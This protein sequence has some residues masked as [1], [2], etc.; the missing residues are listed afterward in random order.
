MGTGNEWVGKACSTG[1]SLGV[2]QVLE[3]KVA[4]AAA[5]TGEQDAK[6]LF[7][8]TGTV[9][10]LSFGVCDADLN[11]ASATICLGTENDTDLFV[12][13]TTETTIDTDEIWE[14]TSPAKFMAYSTIDAKWAIIN[15]ADIGYEVASA[16]ITSGNMTFLCYWWPVTPNGD[17]RVA[18]SDVDL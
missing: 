9:V 7:S 18:G 17:V 1:K 11:G 14:S 16:D 15:N 2:M 4:F 6:E 5:T 13:A 10:A 3:K 8:V 12:A